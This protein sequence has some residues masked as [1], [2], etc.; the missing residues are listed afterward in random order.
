[1]MCKNCGQS[2]KPRE[3]YG[4][5]DWRLTVPYHAPRGI[6]QKLGSLALFLFVAG[7]SLAFWAW[8]LGWLA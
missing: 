2:H 5:R 4:P 1:M 3:Y 8:L 6:G 7:C